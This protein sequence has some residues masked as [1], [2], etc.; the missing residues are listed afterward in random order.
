[1]QLGGGL[2]QHTPDL[3]VSHSTT[4]TNKLTKVMGADNYS[5]AAE[6]FV[7]QWLR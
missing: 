7:S 5:R 3:G 6:L 4:N 2:V 1:M